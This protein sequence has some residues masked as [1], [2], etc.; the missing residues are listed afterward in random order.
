MIRRF[1][2][3]FVLFAVMTPLLAAC[4]ERDDQRDELLDIIE[5]SRHRPLEVVY[6]DK[7]GESEAKVTAKVEDDFRFKAL[8]GYDGK[9]SYEQVVHD[10]ALA[11]RF[12]DPAHVPTLIDKDRIASV[13]LH[14][15]IEGITVLEALQSGRWV[16]D[17]GAAPLVAR[18]PLGTDVGR[19]FV[20]DALTSLDYLRRAVGEAAGVTEWSDD[21]LS[22]A[23]SSSE[24]TFPKP[25]EGSGVTRYDLVRPDLPSGAGGG[26]S[27]EAVVLATRHFRKM[28]IYVK[29]GYVIRAIEKVEAIG[30]QV[31]DL[32][33]YFENLLEE[34][35]APAALQRELRADLEQTP[36]E[37]LGANLLEAVNSFLQV[38]GQEAVLIREMTLDLKD[39]EDASIGLPDADVIRAPLDL[40]TVSAAAQQE[41]EAQG[42]ENSGESG[43]TGGQDGGGFTPGAGQGVDPT[44]GGNPPPS[45]GEAPPAAG[46]P[47]GGP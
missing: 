9:P 14:T 42:A 38:A 23:Y 25:E 21:D 17:E 26:A 20:L 46:T 40:L 43:G 19:D 15:D 37:Q 4:G 27:G 24:D 35:K 33:D 18:A 45:E 39:A 8:V 11:V 41:A 22:P 44:G 10:D 6:V 5:D 3:F 36:S 13:D 12:V 16:M 47:P 29:D 7:R 1:V 31:E 34:A 32:A 28:A 2:R 30:K